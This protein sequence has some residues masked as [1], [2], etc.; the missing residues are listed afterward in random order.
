MAYN[1]NPYLYNY[2]NYYPQVQAVPNTTQATS[3][4]DIIWVQG[5]AGAKAYLVA[6]NATVTLWDSESPTIYLKTTDA[7]GVPSMKI[8][9]FKERTPAS[10]NTPFSP[11]SD[12]DNIKSLSDELTALKSKYNDIEARLSDMENKSASKRKK[13]DAE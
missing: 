5:E 1:Y 3:S 13:E 4:N 10:Q 11:S 9:D 12:K 2:G 7:R 8:L 6:P